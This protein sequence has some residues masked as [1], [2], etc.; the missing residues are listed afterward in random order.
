MAI[1]YVAMLRKEGYPKP[2]TIT[3]ASLIFKLFFSWEDGNRC[4]ATALR[5]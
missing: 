4:A 5:L 2:E 3:Q 1:Q